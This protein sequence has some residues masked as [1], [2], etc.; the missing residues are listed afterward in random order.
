MEP[1]HANGRLLA[2]EDH[3]SLHSKTTKALAIITCTV[4]L[5]LA[6]GFL[7]ITVTPKARASQ[8]QWASDPQLGDYEEA[9]RE[10]EQHLDQRLHLHLAQALQSAAQH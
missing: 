8:S 4:G 10:L 1:Q 9:Q 2:L 5:G 6:A 7:G 3:M